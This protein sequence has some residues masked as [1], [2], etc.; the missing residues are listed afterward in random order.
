MSWPRTASL[1]SAEGRVRQPV[2]AKHPGRTSGEVL[3]R[4]QEGF[5]CGT[6]RAAPPR[7]MAPA[8]AV[9]WNMTSSLYETCQELFADYPLAVRS[10]NQRQTV[11]SMV[12][13][14]TE[15]P[16]IRFFVLSQDRSEG[17]PVY[18]LSPWC[19]CDRVDIEKDS[20]DGLT[21]AEVKAMTRAV[22]IPRHGSLFGWRSG[23]TV[24]ALVAF[25][26][27]CTPNH[28]EPSWKVMPLADIPRDCWPPFTSEAL[29]GHWFWSHQRVGRIVSLGGLI[30]RKPNTVFWTEREKVLGQDCC[31]VKHDITSPE[32]YTL[33]TGR[34]VYYKALQMG[35]PVPSV[36]SLLADVDKVDLAPRFQPSECNNP[37]SAC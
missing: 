29:L 34:Y 11:C 22:P 16:D 28:R 21:K 12:L 10:I 35:E 26:A 18:S 17:S 14:L 31:V 4:D 23:D 5:S 15:A 32:G 9:V 7:C 27:D 1:V 19:G 2:I 25:H 3:G 33:R 13:I 8:Q 24:T 30:A 6:D 36:R 20:A 37:A